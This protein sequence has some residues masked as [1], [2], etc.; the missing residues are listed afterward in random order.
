M[1]VHLE[2][3]VITTMM[4]EIIEIA[5]EVV[6]NMMI[7][8]TEIHMVDQDLLMPKDLIKN[9][10]SYRLQKLPS[11]LELLKHGDLEKSLVDSLVKAKEYSPLLLV[12]LVLMELLTVVSII[13][14]VILLNLPLAVWPEIV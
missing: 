9:K 8:M 6:E 14:L 12:L 2:S 7:M 1:L 3:I 11:Q 13:K 5:V 10:R 4:I